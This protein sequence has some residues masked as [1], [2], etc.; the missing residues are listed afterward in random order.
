MTNRV[1]GSTG[2]P[3]TPGTPGTA[4][5]AGTTDNIARCVLE[6]L[7]VPDKIAAQ[8]LISLDA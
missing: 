7:D 5:T 6:Q 1:A 2:T 3:G 4:G 8:R